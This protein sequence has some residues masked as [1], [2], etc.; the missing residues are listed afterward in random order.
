MKREWIKEK[1]YVE[2]MTKLSKITYHLL[3]LKYKSQRFI[4]GIFEGLFKFNFLNPL[5]WLLMVLIYIFFF[6]GAMFDAIAQSMKELRLLIS[7]GII[8]EVDMDY[9]SSNK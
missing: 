2:N 1:D 5:T 6:I 4:G 3:M 8:V 7:E 9:K